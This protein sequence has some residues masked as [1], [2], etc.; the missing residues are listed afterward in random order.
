VVSIIILK[1]EI[2]KNVYPDLQKLYPN[3]KIDIN[4]HIDTIMTK[5]ISRMKR[6]NYKGTI[7]YYMCSDQELVKSVM[8]VPCTFDT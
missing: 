6:G 7:I 3:D 8:I 1:I 5:I 2:D 4:K